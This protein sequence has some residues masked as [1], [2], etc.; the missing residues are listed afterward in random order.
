MKKLMLSLA[1]ILMLICWGW[2]GYQGV[3]TAPALSQ[4]PPPGYYY[5]CDPNYYQCDYYNY[6]SAPYTD[7]G[8]QFFYYTLPWAG[9]ELEEHL[10][11]RE[12]REH[13]HPRGHREEHPRR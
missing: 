11:H 10:E 12:Y 5:S 1:L 4:P 3:G 13:E 2:Q 7:P 8:T 6:Y 9:G